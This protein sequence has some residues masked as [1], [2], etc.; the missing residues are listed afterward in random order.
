MAGHIDTFA[1]RFSRQ[2]D[3]EAR[4]LVFL[5]R[6]DFTTP[7]DCFYEGDVPHWEQADWARK[8]WGEIGGP[9]DL[10]LC[11]EQYDYYAQLAE[12]CKTRFMS[13]VVEGRAKRLVSED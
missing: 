7:Q 5:L 9:L 13:D 11:P 2:G 6:R 4:K 8:T 3:P 1:L 12:E 10:C